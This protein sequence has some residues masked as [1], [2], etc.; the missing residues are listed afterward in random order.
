M[1]ADSEMTFLEHVS[2]LRY[3]FLRVILCLFLFTFIGF[4]FSSYILDLLIKPISGIIEKSEVGLQ[5]SKP[6]SIFITKISI[7]LF[8]SFI[9]SMPVILYEI[10]IFL[11]PAFDKKIIL[12]KVYIFILIAV[13]FFISG[14][15]F[16]YYILV[17]VSLDFFNYM[18]INF[19]DSSKY[20]TAMIQLF[21]YNDYILYLLRMSFVTG[22]VFQLPVIV[23]ILVFMNIVK[24]N[25]LKKLR[26]YLYLIFFIVA[27]IL[28]PPDIPTQLLIAIPSIFLY[29]LSILIASIFKNEK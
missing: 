23:N 5:I 26:R 10:F 27:A 9:L 4:Y 2:E 29:E 15:I 20:G 17:P 14:L 24:I 11:L 18:T 25:T 16:S 21:N 3:R 8:F 19:I 13:S 7:G 12:S 1:N 22:L 6:T 28:T